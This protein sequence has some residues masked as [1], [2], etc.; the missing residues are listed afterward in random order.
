MVARTEDV[1]VHQ[2][3]KR[4]CVCVC[5]CG[6]VLSE[7]VSR[8]DENAFHDLPGWQSLGHSL[9]VGVVRTERLEPCREAKEASRAGEIAASR[10]RSMTR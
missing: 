6:V 9:R 5:V 1:V 10:G 7:Q 8:Q 2:L 3:P 4:V